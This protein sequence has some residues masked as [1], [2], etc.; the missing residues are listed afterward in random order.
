MEKW[1]NINGFEGY[2]Q[3][4]N[5]GN[6]RSIDRNVYAH[7][8]KRILKL[9][10]KTLKP[11]KDE[12]GYFRVAL[13]KNKKLQTFKV[14]RLVA[15]HFCDNYSSTLEVNHI[16]GNRQN[17]NYLNLEWVTHSKNIKHSFDIG[18]SKP[19]Q[20][21]KNPNSKL[22]EQDVIEI[23]KIASVKKHY[24]RKELSKQFGVSEKHIQDIVN[25]KELWINAKI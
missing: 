1:E 12:D 11:A 24:G 20:G 5:F 22:S 14:H 10:G 8:G 23:R 3:V 6:I 7:Q 17:N 15:L 25:N 13:C 18:L 4:S 16:D 9:K 21:S 19:K 2:Y